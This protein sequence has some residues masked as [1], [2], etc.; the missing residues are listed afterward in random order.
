MPRWAIPGLTPIRK[1]PSTAKAIRS[2]TTSRSKSVLVPT[3]PSK[4]ASANLKAVDWGS[5][6]PL[7][8]FFAPVAGD[9][10]CSIGHK[11]GRNRQR[12]YE[13]KRTLQNIHSRRD[14]L[15]ARRK[16]GA[17]IPASHSI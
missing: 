12:Y 5:G 13:F 8:L 11:G 7:P 1:A 4:S 10:P 14:R 9:S 6:Q 16:D 3:S 15:G 2:T 17:R